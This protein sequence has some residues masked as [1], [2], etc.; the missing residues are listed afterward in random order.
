MFRSR[1][2]IGDFVINCRFVCRFICPLRP[3]QKLFVE[4]NWNF[5]HL[6]N[7]SRQNH[8]ASFIALHIFLQ[9][10][11]Y[12]TLESTLGSC[13]SNASWLGTR[14]ASILG[15]CHTNTKVVL[16]HATCR[17]SDASCKALHH[18]FRSIIYI[19]DRQCTSTVFQYSCEMPTWMEGTGRHTGHGRPL[20]S[21]IV[22][23][24]QVVSC[25]CA[26]EWQQSTHRGS[27][28]LQ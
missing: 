1:V 20:D 5:A 3:K 16:A 7:Y 18:S 23:T 14:I 26:G 21:S 12:C 10:L 19:Y 4:C 27:A 11:W 22:Y 25:K 2:L 15:P 8:L 13:D 6:S 28:N 17:N 9:K 24:A